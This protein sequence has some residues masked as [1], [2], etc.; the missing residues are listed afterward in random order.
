MGSILLGGDCDDGRF[1][2]W[3]GAP[4]LCNETDDDCDGETDEADALDAPTWYTDADGDGYGD[5][6]SPVVSCS[7]AV[8][9]VSNPDDCDDTLASVFPGA[10]EV[11]SDGID[12]DCDGEDL[13][14]PL[15]TG[16]EPGWYHGNYGGVGEFY[17]ASVGYNGTVSCPTT[18]AAF[19]LSARGMRFVCNL[20][21]GMPGGSGEGC[22]PGNE[23]Q[24]GEDNC[25]QMVRD[26]VSKTENGNTEDCA[27]GA[28]MSC[29]TGSCSEGVTWHSIEC[30][31]G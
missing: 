2:V 20:Q 14:A 24:Y 12:Q 26:M 1:D 22:H 31:C 18:C 3:P 13:E 5:I 29:V 25:G 4:E 6:D 17:D 30:Q 27:G 15:H 8:G 11:E 28:T 21:Y 7:A 10:P 16:S 23:G 9:T 19:G